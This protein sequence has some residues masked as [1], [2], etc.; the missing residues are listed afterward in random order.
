MIYDIYISY[1]YIVIKYNN[2]FH[3]DAYEPTSMLGWDEGY[4]AWEM[5]RTPNTWQFWML[6]GNLTKLLK[7]AIEIVN[8]PIKHG[9]FPIKHW[10][11]QF[12]YN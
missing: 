10:K 4:G 8:F 3:R 6:S 1:I 5:M 7:M 11:S 12:V 2:P 9:D